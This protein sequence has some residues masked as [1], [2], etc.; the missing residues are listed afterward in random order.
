MLAKCLAFMKDLENEETTPD[1]L[2]DS[3]FFMEIKLC[4]KNFGIAQKM[5]L[6]N[7][8]LQRRSVTMDEDN[9]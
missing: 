7:K 2:L 6:W 4:S 9:V 3:N 1:A 5:L 8:P